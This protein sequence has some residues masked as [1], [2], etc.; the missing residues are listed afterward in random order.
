MRAVTP[1]LF[2][3]GAAAVTIAGMER[4]LRRAAPRPPRVRANYGLWVLIGAAAG[5]VIGVMIGNTAVGIVIGAGVGLALAETI[6]RIRRD[7]Q[8]HR[9][10][11]KHGTH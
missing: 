7:L 5:V 9:E 1:F 11:M 2:L 6:A 3:S 4:R 8:T 10:R